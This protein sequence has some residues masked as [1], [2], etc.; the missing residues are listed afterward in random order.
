MDER[1]DLM[2]AKLFT[3]RTILR[4]ATAV[5]VAASL[6]AP[7]VRGAYAAGKLSMGAWDHWV[8]GAG[9]VLNDICKEW[10]DKEKVD[11]TLDLITSNGDKDLLTLMAEGQAKAGHDIIG[12]RLWYVSAEKDN[13]V[14][15]DDIVDEMIKKNGPISAACE[16]TGKV[17][18]HW[19]A[20]PGSYGSGAL[21]PCAR[22]D[23]MKE[24]GGIDVLKMYPPPGGAP[25]MELRNSWTWENFLV[26]ADK[27]AKAGHFFG[28]GLS[29][30]TDAINMAGAVF[31]AYGAELVDRDGNITIAKNDKIA[32][33]LE[34]FQ[35]L[36]KTLPDEVYAYD[37]A[38]NNKSIISGQTALIFNPPSAYAVAKRDA[39]KVAEQLWTFP[40]PK[41]PMGR[42]D[43]SGYYYWGI[44]NFS[45]NVSAA[46]S[47]LAYISTR[48]IQEKLV[49]ASLGFDIPP[50]KSWLDFPTWAE[51]G[52]PKGTNYNYPPRNDVIPSISGYPA[53][54]RIG[55]QIYAQATMTKMIA[56][57]TQQGRSIK[58][59]MAWA[60][61]EIEGFMR[62]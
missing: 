55:T 3:R 11:L 57:C 27:C 21:P 62:T 36:A 45:K 34:W 28:L 26:A 1:E 9:K 48:E 59:S 30:C 43:P 54:L 14:P 2:D 49:A 56:M 61:S 46:K 51:E 44:W 18:G 53:P 29:T 8:P 58:D 10:A 33:V 40:S 41:G 23:Y 25:D 5:P 17:D 39:P 60:E 52:P 31:Q 19:M 15:V 50:F 22:I 35:K 7:F 12:L 37:N 47:L 20:V 38:S 13:F 24:L 4:T 32:Q 16:Y 6:S 42:F